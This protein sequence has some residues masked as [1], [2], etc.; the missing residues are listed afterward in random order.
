MAT[1]SQINQWPVAPPPSQSPC[2]QLS[3]VPMMNL[4]SL[5]S[6]LQSLFLTQSCTNHNSVLCQLWIHSP[7][8]N[9]VMCQSSI[10]SPCSHL[11]PAPIKNLQSLFSTQSCVNDND[12]STVPDL[13]STLCQWWPTVPAL[14]S[15]LCQRWIYYLCSQLTPGTMNLQI[16]SSA[17]PR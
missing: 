7:I 4:Q 13:N 8:P 3:S 6:T 11:S 5:F 12:E 2:S 15:V 16:L 10:Y 1:P 17:H 14:N 9:T